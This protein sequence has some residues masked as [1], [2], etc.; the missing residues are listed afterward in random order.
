MLLL[1]LHP[2]PNL[3]HRLILVLQILPPLIINTLPIL[4]PLQFNLRPFLKLNNLLLDVSSDFGLLVPH[5]GLSTHSLLMF[6]PLP[7]ASLMFSPPRP[8]EGCLCQFWHCNDP[9]VVCFVLPLI[10]TFPLVKKHVSV[11]PQLCAVRSVVEVPFS[12]P[13]YLFL[14]HFPFPII[15]H[16]NLS[17]KTD[18]AV[19]L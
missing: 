19:R 6:F 18:P 12:L 10:P 4:P 9:L 15:V 16:I 8:L 11:V 3:Q 13:L 7:F 2:L 5:L 1:P 14:F 17:A